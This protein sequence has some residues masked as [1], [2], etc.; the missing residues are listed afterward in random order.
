MKAWVCERYGSPD[1]LQLREMDKPIPGD[2]EVL[3][4]VRAAGLNAYDWHIVRGDPYLVRMVKGLRRPRKPAVVGSDMA[5]VVEAVGSGV[6]KSQPGDEVYAEVD[7]GGLGEYAAVK[8]K[9]LARKPANLTFEQAAAVPMAALTALQGLR[10]TARLQP[11]EKVLVHGAGG[12]VGSFAVQIA[13]A[14][15]AS[16]VTGVCG[17]AKLE[18]V[19][20]LGA[21][22]V[23]D[24]S[25]EDFTRDGRRYDV[26]LDTANRSLRA[27]RRVMVP[28]G[29]LAIVGGRGGRV[30]G[31]VPQYIAASILSPI[32]RKKMAVV[33]GH[34]SGEDLAA[35]AE[36]IEAGRIKP[37]LDRVF[38]F[39][40]APEAIRLLEEGQ[41]RGKV[42]VAVQAA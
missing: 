26:V 25:R 40:D 16:E 35:L 5:G 20:S 32:V 31:P 3:V 42:V 30:L 24:R 27:V 33:I 13:K 14:L 19:R 10:D 7:E 15:G 39:A 18:M 28:R 38:L 41:V 22:H 9:L 2:D 12:G 17:P 21:D 6:T 36:M 37:A 34:R 8:E 1:T 4:R 29:R 23:V 11:G